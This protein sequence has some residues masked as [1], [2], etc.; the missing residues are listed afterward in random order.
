MAL[1]TSQIEPSSS[2]NFL[3]MSRYFTVL[4]PSSSLLTIAL[5]SAMRFRLGSVAFGLEPVD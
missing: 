1:N 4:P 2:T 5:I 3:P